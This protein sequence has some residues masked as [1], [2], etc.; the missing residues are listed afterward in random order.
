MIKI[1]ARNTVGEKKHSKFENRLYS[2]LLTQLKSESRPIIDKC[3]ICG[4]EY[5]SY[6]DSHSVPRFVLKQISKN[7]K[8]MIGHN[9]TKNPTFND[10]GIKNTL[11]FKCICEDCD[12]TYF[13]EYE[14]PNIFNKDL[15]NLAINEIAIKIYLRHYYKRLGEESIFMNLFDKVQSEGLEDSDIG[16]FVENKLLTTK[17]DLDDAKRRI[18][19]L[20]KHKEERHFYII[21]EFVLDY[22]TELAFQGFV[23]LSR[24]F[25]KQINDLHNYDP[26]Y[27]I[28]LLYICVFPFKDGTKVL[29]FCEDGFKR[30]RDFY[31]EYRKLDLQSKLY[32]INYILLLYDEEWCVSGDFD[33]TKLNKETLSLINQTTDINVEGNNL[34]ELQEEYQKLR[35]MLL[36]EVFELK[37]SGDVYNFLRRHQNS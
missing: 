8:I 11:L 2:K 29:L 25:S 7:G 23:A 20:I 37:T 19:R 27:K 5:S 12:N 14:D 6:C 31:K 35:K 10:F 32:L 15:S 1:E 18:N 33:K 4:K 24:G 21:D 16:H 17:L 28:E 30:L 3:V 22:P 9:F 36:D 34:V 13:K 26:S